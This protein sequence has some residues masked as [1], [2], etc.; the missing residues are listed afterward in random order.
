[1]PISGCRRRSPQGCS[2]SRHREPILRAFSVEASSYV[3]PAVPDT[4]DPY[5]TTIQWSRR[6]IG[7]KVFMSIAEL[8]R[9][10]LAA[11]IEHH[12]AM[13]RLL[14]E[15]LTAN[16]WRLVKDSPLAVVCFT[17]PRIDGDLL[18]TS[19]VVDRVV[20][21]GRAWISEARLGGK[22]SVLRA[23]ITSYRTQPADIGILI[24]ELEHAI[25]TA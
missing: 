8:G 22:Q 16:G 3:P 24:D 18:S 10:G 5:V 6:F 21:S 17:H 15:R 11:Q 25:A 19:Q 1:M 13:A 20:R 2:F 9:D 12:V 14:R 4:F 7:L 23:C